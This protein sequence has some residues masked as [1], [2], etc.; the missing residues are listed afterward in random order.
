[1]FVSPTGARVA[2]VVSYLRGSPDRRPDGTSYDDSSPYATWQTR[3]YTPAQLSAIFA[4]DTRTS[5]GSLT[6]LDLRNRGVSGRLISVTLIGSAGSKTVSGDVFIGVFNA[7][8]S[9]G[10]P[11]LRSTLLGLSPIP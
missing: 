1:V 11:M 10:D 2:G 9:S 3:A 6:A 7:A 4:S 8:R 5:V